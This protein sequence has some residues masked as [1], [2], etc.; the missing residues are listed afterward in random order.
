MRLPQFDRPIGIKDEAQEAA[1][2]PELAA[3]STD[4]NAPQERPGSGSHE[5][6]KVQTFRDDKLLHDFVPVRKEPVVLRCAQLT[7]DDIREFIKEI[8]N[9]ITEA[10]FKKFT[11]SSN[12]YEPTGSLIETL[13]DDTCPEVQLY[14]NSPF[15]REEVGRKTVR[16]RKSLL[17][18][19]LKSV[20]AQQ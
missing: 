1:A 12:T 4:D 15:K 14:K 2:Q 13:L 9:K 18:S 5:R 7:Q 17:T 19:L 6:T 16:V 8:V 10:A 3:D 20:C 11:T